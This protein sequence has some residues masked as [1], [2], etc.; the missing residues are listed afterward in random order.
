MRTPDIRLLAAVALALIVALAAVANSTPATADPALDTEEQNFID[1]INNYRQQNGRSNL[2]P[3]TSLQNAADWMSADLGANNYFSHTDSLGRSPWDRMAAFGYGYN[4]WKGENIAAGYSTAQGA[5]NAW[6][7]SSGHNANM[8]SANFTV[9]GIARVYTP[10][11]SYGWYW[12][13]DFGGYNPPGPPQSTPTPSPVPTPT[14]PPT[15]SPTP[16]PTLAPSPTPSPAASPGD[17]DG[18]GFSNAAEIHLG[19]DPYLACGDPDPSKSSRASRAW[20]ADL[21][22]LSGGD[23]SRSPTSRASSSPCEDLAPRWA[24]RTTIGDGI[25]TTGMAVSAQR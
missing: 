7:N 9:M 15:P 21:N 10:G 8:L 6:R 4:T 16:V 13:N 25:S 19:T 18:D 17:S 5:F 24:T 1:L 2:S 22:T 20:P 14:P 12:T 23:A 3:T 11:S